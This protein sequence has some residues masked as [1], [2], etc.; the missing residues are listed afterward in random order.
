M[1]VDIPWF[2]PNMV[3]QID[4]KT[5]TDEEE[6][7]Y[8]SSQHSTCHSVHLNNAVNLMMQS[9]NRR[10]QGYMPNDMPARFLV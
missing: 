10:L 7:H 6:I 2:V 1:I 5:S 3:I 9:N 4:F 8:Y